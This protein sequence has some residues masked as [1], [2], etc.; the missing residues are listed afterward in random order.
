M[1][2]ALKLVRGGLGIAALG[3]WIGVSRAAA[4]V[5]EWGRRAR[6]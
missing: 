1:K 5:Q 6:P 3:A 2:D 4:K